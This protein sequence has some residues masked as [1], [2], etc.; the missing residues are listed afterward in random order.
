MIHSTVKKSFL[1]SFYKKIISYKHGNYILQFNVSQDLFSSQNIDYGTQR[2]LRSLLYEKVNDYKKVLDLGCGYGPIG[3]TLKK[4]CPKAEVHMVDRDALALEYSAANA[5][6]NGIDDGVAVYGSLGY[7]SVADRDFDLIASNIPAK[8]GERVLT[9]IIK[10]VAFHLVEKGRVAIVVIDAIADYIHQELSTDKGIKILYHRS[11][12]GH[13]VYHYTFK[14]EALREKPENKKAFESGKY[15]KQ[16]NTFRFRGETLTLK[17]TF[18]LSE[19]NQLSYDSGILLSNLSKIKNKLNNVL[20]FN[21]G[22]GYIPLAVEKQFSPKKIHL[23]DR[24]LQALRITKE[25]LLDNGYPGTQISTHHQVG[26]NIGNKNLEAIIGIVSEKQG[27]G[28]YKL[29]IEQAQNLVN[30]GGYLLLSSSS[31]VITRI[32]EIISKKALFKILF[33]ERN[34][35]RSVIFLKKIGLEPSQNQ[36]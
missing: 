33:R 17:T 8:V 19:F 1:D 29:L 14:P 12:P 2:L 34:K 18:H 25:N 35:G 13:H 5:K 10:D 21:P 30:I 28:V 6:L 20:I 3:I 7:D 36:R 22:Q 31:T 15:H 23:V 27:M 11:W 26:L 9:H 16:K 4:V 24:D 32:Q